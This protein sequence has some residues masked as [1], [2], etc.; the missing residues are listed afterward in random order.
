MPLNRV[1][2]LLTPLV[3]APLAGL[4][5]LQAA[6]LGLDLPTDEALS[7]LVEVFTYGVGAVIA[8]MKSRQWL[9]GWQLYEE[10]NDA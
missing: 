3:F 1:V 2:V 10:R 7:S 4:I 6:K 9:N 8:F 5:T